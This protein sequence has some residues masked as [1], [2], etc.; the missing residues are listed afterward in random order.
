[1]CLTRQRALAH[2]RPEFLLVVHSA[3]WGQGLLWPELWKVQRGQGKGA[4]SPPN[5][6]TTVCQSCWN[7]V[8][9]GTA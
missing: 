2:V 9:L 5:I 4:E 3:L 1:M 6:M 8:A 7:K